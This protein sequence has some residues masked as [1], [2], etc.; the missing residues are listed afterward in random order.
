M[1]KSIIWVAGEALIDLVPIGG[2]SGAD[3]WW[4][5]ANTAK[6]LAKLG[7][8][9]LFIG[10][11]LAMSMVNQLLKNLILLIYLRRSDQTYRPHSR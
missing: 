7:I 9:T 5:P 1:N 3:C 4:G 6:A 8:D 2:F 10:G 11:I